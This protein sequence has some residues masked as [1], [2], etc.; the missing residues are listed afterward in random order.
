MNISL[1]EFFY[2]DVVYIVF[3]K[4]SFLIIELLEN[5]RRSMIFIF[6]IPKKTKSFRTLAYSSKAYFNI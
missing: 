5:R 2:N 6:N 1:F 3:P 4:R